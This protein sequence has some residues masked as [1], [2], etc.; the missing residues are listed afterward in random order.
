MHL[1]TGY[2]LGEILMCSLFILSFII[3]HKPKNMEGAINMLLILSATMPE[4]ILIQKIYEE[5]KEC[6]LFPEDRERKKALA[7]YCTM[8][9][10]NQ[11]TE[12]DIKKAVK[13]INDMESN[14][15]KLS[16]FDIDKLRS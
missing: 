12:G 14:Q 15:K 7:A 4:D 3:N 2:I 13:T 16:L 1:E 9:I 10:M 8:F 6:L 5:T 11:E